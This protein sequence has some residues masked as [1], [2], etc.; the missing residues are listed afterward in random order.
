[1]GYQRILITR[2]VL[3]LHTLPPHHFTDDVDHHQETPLTC[4]HLK[5]Q[6]TAGYDPDRFRGAER[7]LVG[8]IAAIRRTMDDLSST[9]AL[10]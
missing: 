6:Y 2:F 7:F 10:F 4:L 1:M 9:V 3:I 8:H 5:D